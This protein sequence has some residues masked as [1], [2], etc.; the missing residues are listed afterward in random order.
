MTD[1]RKELSPSILFSMPTESL[2]PSTEET[3]SYVRKTCCGQREVLY[4]ADGNDVV[5]LYIEVTPENNAV[6]STALSAVEAACEEVKLFK[7]WTVASEEG[8]RAAVQVRTQ[9]H[10]DI[11]I[12]IGE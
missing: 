5:V 2:D 9:V 7:G 3:V 10:N 11:D 12:P 6:V 1:E 8:K 4:P